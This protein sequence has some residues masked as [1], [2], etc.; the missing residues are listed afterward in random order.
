MSPILEKNI[1][2]EKK[3]KKSYFFKVLS[4]CFLLVFL[5]SSPALALQETK[6]SVKDPRIKYADYRADEVFPILTKEGFVTTISFE[7]GEEVTSYGSGF[8]SA[9]ETATGENQFLK[10]KRLDGETNFIIVTDKRVYSFEVRYAGRG[11][12]PTFR[13]IFRYPGTEAA[14]AKEKEE[15]KAVEEAIKQ[16]SISTEAVSPR[17]EADGLTDEQMQ[18]LRGRG[19]F[20]ASFKKPG[21][22]RR[23]AKSD[24]YNWKY[25]MNFGENPG[26]KDI[27]PEAV[28][29]D[30]RFTVIRFPP[31]AEIPNVYQVL[32]GEDAGG[33][34]TLLKT[35]MDPES[36]S[37]IVEKTAKEFRLRNGEAVV[38]IYNEGFGE[39]VLSAKSGTTVKKVKR[40][41]TKAANHE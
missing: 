12:N 27:A 39:K 40:T 13:L 34:E 31:Y 35:R 30:G 24:P 25:S 3:M 32:P 17:E 33:Q 2:Q 28:Y 5:G 21:K 9:W 22:R 14:L 7:K 16:G 36:H 11:E 18:A 6:G 8:S 26:S 15:R 10:P 1:V 29:D 37:L 19:I 4:S 38:G 20:K 41:W 23:N